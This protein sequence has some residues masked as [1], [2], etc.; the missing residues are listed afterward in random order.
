MPWVERSH[1]LYGSYWIIPGIS[2]V[3]AAVLAG[4]SGGAIRRP[5]G[6]SSNSSSPNLKLRWGC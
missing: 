4:Y 5:L 1:K 3:M 6:L 2:A